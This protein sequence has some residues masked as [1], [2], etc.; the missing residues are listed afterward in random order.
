MNN[1]Q[2]SLARND[3]C[4]QSKWEYFKQH[5]LNPHQI[6]SF[7]YRVCCSTLKV[8]QNLT[9]HGLFTSS[10]IWFCQYHVFLTYTCTSSNTFCAS[11]KDFL[12]QQIFWTPLK[13]SHLF[14]PILVTFTLSIILIAGKEDTIMK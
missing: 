4:L 11:N 14:L 3:S 5:K 1:T 12:H 8:M 10:L 2:N 13:L 7:F 6:N 9:N